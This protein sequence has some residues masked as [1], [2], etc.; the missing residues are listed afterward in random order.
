[1]AVDPYALCPC[2]SGRKLKFCCGDILLDM[3]RVMRL[4]ENQPEAAVK[5]LRDLYRKHPDKDVVLRELCHTLLELNEVAE[6]RNAVQ[7]FLRR[8]PDQPAGLLTQAEIGLS[9]SGFA[10]AR[11]AIHRAFQICTRSMPAQVAHLA[12][13]IAAHNANRGFLFAAREHLALAVRLATGERQRALVMELINLESMSSIPMAFRCA[14]HLLPLSLPEPA[15][16]QELRARKLSSLG[17]WEPAAILYNRLADQFPT[18]GAVWFNLGLCQAWDARVQEAAGSLHHAATL[19]SDFDLAAEAEAL[20]QELS[21]LF[22]SERYSTV[23]VTLKVRSVS[24]LLSRLQNEADIVDSPTHDHSEC[25]HGHGVTHAAELALLSESSAPDGR[26][27]SFALHESIADIDVFDLDVEPDPDAE[28]GKDEATGYI[29]ITALDNR[30]DEAIVRLRAAAGDLIVT[31]ADQEARSTV[32]HHVTF[33]R[34]FDRNPATLK[35]MTQ[36]AFTELLRRLEPGMVEAWLNQPTELLDNKSPLEAAALPELRTKLAACL[37]VMQSHAAEHEHW[38]DLVSLRARLGLPPR[39]S[40]SIP[41]GVPVA[42]IPTLQFE[43]LDLAALTDTQIN[44]LANRCSVLGLKRLASKALDEVATRPA[45]MT[46]FG[47]RRLRLMQSAIARDDMNRGLAFEYL[48]KARESIEPGADA[49]RFQLETDVRELTYRLDDPQDPDLIPLLHR[50][51]D[52][53]LHKIPEIESIILEQLES[54]GCGHLAT[55]LHGG[56][57]TAG[58]ASGL[59]IPGQSAAAESGNASK[60]W[61]PGQPE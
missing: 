23:S 19:L 18:E 41:Q 14:W 29:E 56:L 48:K 30:M 31:T 50:F 45:A 28:A 44:E 36:S 34:P 5:M 26:G 58:A 13:R 53:Y 35:G 54:A 39:A 55:E 7:E 22:T 15:A 10:G 43:R 27:G 37:L 49:F 52:R 57:V 9:E 25:D 42:S 61:I 12:A 8:H 16:Q 33:A 4:R 60:L 17:C 24:E 51:R 38:P 2:G 21:L 6:A 20:A 1:M 11:R 32:K 3:Q 59:W 47:A 46:A 40:V